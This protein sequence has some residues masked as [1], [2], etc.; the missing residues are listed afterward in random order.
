MEIPRFSL[1]K[2]KNTIDEPDTL[3]TLVNKINSAECKKPKP[4]LNVW[5]LFK[6][7][8]PLNSSERVL[9]YSNKL[10][11]GHYEINVS[12]NVLQHWLFDTKIKNQRSYFIKW[13]RID[14]NYK[15]D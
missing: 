15:E 7:R 11:Q 4:K 14:E 5:N 9:V 2:S 10:S 1:K 6:D 12:S 13:M 3:I 8:L